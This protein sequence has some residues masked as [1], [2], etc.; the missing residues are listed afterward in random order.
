MNLGIGSV[1]TGI[2]NFADLSI[3]I[4]CLL[5]L[6]SSWRRTPSVDR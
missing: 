4:G 6:A 2:F 3:L 5:I 1:R